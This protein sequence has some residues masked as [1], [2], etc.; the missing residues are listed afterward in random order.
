MGLQALEG[1]R[2]DNP[3]QTERLEMQENNGFVLHRIEKK[4]L[5]TN[6]GSSGEG[7]S[8]TELSKEEADCLA[9]SSG[10]RA[11]V[12]PPQWGPSPRS[13]SAPEPVPYLESLANSSLHRSS[14]PAAP[15]PAGHTCPPPQWG[16][17][18]RT[19]LILR[20]FPCPLPLPR[21]HTALSASHCRTDHRG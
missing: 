17:S 14:S 13:A 19:A 10:S 7:E 1:S 3:F 2:R 8:Q 4:K 15:S 6:E 9:S 18:P 16:P 11:H 21:G 12:P 20:P 5:E